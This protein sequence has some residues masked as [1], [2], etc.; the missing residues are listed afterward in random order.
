METAVVS[1][2]FRNW[3]T[4]LQKK[5]VIERENEFKEAILK[6]NS[7]FITESVQASKENR[8]FF[9]AKNLNTRLETR[10]KRRIES[11]N[12]LKVKKNEKL[13]RTNPDYNNYYNQLAHPD[14]L[15][16]NAK[17][18]LYKQREAGYLKEYLLRCVPAQSRLKNC[19]HMCTT[20]YLLVYKIIST[21]YCFQSP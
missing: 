15:S 6:D 8:G 18:D 3:K 16:L 20:D 19:G 13:C 2:N 10:R 17:V 11:W 4:H 1:N 14:T 12:M 9:L 5:L 7:N 21:K